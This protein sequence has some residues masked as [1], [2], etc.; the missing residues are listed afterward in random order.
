M[1]QLR[2]ITT[3]STNRALGVTPKR[4]IQCL[5]T[6][7]GQAAPAFSGSG[8]SPDPTACRGSARRRAIRVRGGRR[9]DQPGTCGGSASSDIQIRRRRDRGGRGQSK[10]CSTAWRMR[11]NH[12]SARFNCRARDWGGPLHGRFSKPSCNCPLRMRNLWFEM[13]TR[14]MGDP[15]EQGPA[16][17]LAAVRLATGISL[18]ALAYLASK[19][20][21][22]AAAG[23]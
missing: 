6:L 12:Q 13:P 8:V 14:R 16:W 18:Y 15:T 23:K 3:A 20:S 5:S 11:P 22:S 21:P 17:R 2:T 9:L 7:R 19:V 10:G 4:A 1:A